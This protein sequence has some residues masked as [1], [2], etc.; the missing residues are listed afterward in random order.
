MSAPFCSAVGRLRP[1]ALFGV[2][3]A[4]SVV[5]ATCGAPP[6][7][8]T[9]RAAAIPYLHEA[10]DS[11]EGLTWTAEGYTFDSSISVLD[12][13]GVYHFRILGPDGSA[14]KSFEIEATKLLH[15]Y[16]IRDDLTGFTHVH[17]T[18]ASDGTWSVVLPGQEPGP[19]HVYATML[20]RDAGQQLH[21]LVLERPL[22]VPGAYRLSPILPAPSMST[23]V[24][25]YTLTY[26]AKPK[27]W[28]VM[29][30]PA[31]FSRAGQPVTDLQSYLGA[32]AHMTSFRQGNFAYGHA[33]P[34]EYAIGSNPGGPTLT[35]HTEFPG[36]GLYRVFVE[37]ET[38]GQLHTAQLTLQVP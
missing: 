29:L 31:R 1:A 26:E 6:S 12:S 25:G 16:A 4:L 30:L 33:H 13:G 24:D 27:A 9:V 2:L 15:F 8:A 14:T 34:L 18:M 36:S 19:H 11:T 10:T 20:I 3:A 32:F 21:V 38:G 35:F 23:T 37:F 28:T 17:P 7:T 5:L 22:M